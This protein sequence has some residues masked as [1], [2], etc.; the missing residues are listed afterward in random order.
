LSDT[1][2]ISMIL[3]YVFNG[4]QCFDYPP[5]SVEMNTIASPFCT[6]YL[7][8]PSSSQS[9]SLIKTRMPG[10]LYATTTTTTTGHTH[11]S[12]PM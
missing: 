12:D 4:M 2:T 5:W 3:Y 9:A 1:G 7:M 11:R 8:P 6:L 10:R